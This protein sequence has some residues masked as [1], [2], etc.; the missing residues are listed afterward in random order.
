MS[1]TVL[2]QSSIKHSPAPTPTGL[3]TAYSNRAISSFETL[4]CKM[5][6]SLCQGDRNLTGS[7]S[8]YLAIEVRRKVLTQMLL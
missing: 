3:P 1:Q 8:V 6:L 2:Y 4:S 7:L 5:N